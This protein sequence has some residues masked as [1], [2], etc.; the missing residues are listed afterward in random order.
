MRHG[1]GR[2]PPRLPPLRKTHVAYIRVGRAQALEG[3]LELRVQRDHPL[4]T[5]LGDVPADVNDGPDRPIGI[6]HVGHGE[7]GDLGGPQARS[8]RQQELNFVALGRIA[9]LSDPTE[10]RC[11]LAFIKD[12][13]PT[14]GPGSR[15]VQPFIIPIV[16]PGENCVIPFRVNS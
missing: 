6:Q 10:R 8:N 3:L 2:L 4:L 15:T 7:A 5:A 12:P 14:T 1:L 11:D 9:G 16:F 13:G